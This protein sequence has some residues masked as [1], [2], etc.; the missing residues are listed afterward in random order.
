MLWL[1]FTHATELKASQPLAAFKTK[2]DCEA[3]RVAKLPDEKLNEMASRDRM[4]GGYAICLPETV[5]PRGPK[6]K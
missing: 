2:D 6:E 1:S 5:D 3:Q 4:V